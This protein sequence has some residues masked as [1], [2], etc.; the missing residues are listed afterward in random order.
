MTIATLM[1]T[2]TLTLHAGCTARVAYLLENMPDLL[3]LGPSQQH[4]TLDV[5]GGDTIWCAARG[6]LPLDLEDGRRVY[7]TLADTRPL[8]PDRGRYEVYWWS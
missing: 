8:D 6:P 4:G 7:V 2:G 1:G 3:A 5:I